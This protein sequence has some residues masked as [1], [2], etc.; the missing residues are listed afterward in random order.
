MRREVFIYPYTVLS[1]DDLLVV[2]FLSSR[3]PALMLF[4]LLT[5]HLFL[6]HTDF[7]SHNIIHP[8]S[9]IQD[10]SPL[11][12][13]TPPILP[14]RPPPLLPLPTIKLLLAQLPIH[15]VMRLTHPPP[16]FIPTLGPYLIFSHVGLEVFGA[17]PA[18]V[19]LGEERHEGLHVGAIGGGGGGRVAG[20]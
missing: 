18:G 6:Y 19:E 15:L 17:D 12:L 11:N 2:L 7:I 8:P 1:R 4:C 10:L 20:C 14:A 5:T 3:T 16:K 9:T 13:T